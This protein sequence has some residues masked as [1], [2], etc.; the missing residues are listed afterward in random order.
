VSRAPPSSAKTFSENSFS[1]GLAGARLPVAER[2]GF[3]SR[4]RDRAGA[5][6]ARP[7]LK[8]ASGF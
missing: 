3:L 8:T 2:A 6:F 7:I 1:A 5:G 4:G